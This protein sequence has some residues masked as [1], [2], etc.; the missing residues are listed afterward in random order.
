MKKFLRPSFLVYSLGLGGLFLTDLIVGAVFSP[1]D[2]ADWAKFRSLVGI[3]AVIPLIGLDQVLMRSPASSAQ[4]LRI[5]GV[6][7]PILGV[8][9]GFIL[10][11]F[12]FVSSWVLGAGLAIGS[13]ASLVLFQYFRA[14]R[15]EVLSQFAQQGWKIAALGLIAAMALT[16]WRSDLVVWGIGL[17]LA[18]DIIVALAVLILPPE[19]LHPQSPEP[20]RAHYAIGSRFMVTSLMLALSVYAEQLVVN[21]LGSHME[22]ALYFTSAT[23]FL[24]PLSFLNGYLAFLMGPWVRDKH[25]RFIQL[26][27]TRWWAI[28]LASAGYGVAMGVLGLIL[29]KVVRPSVGEIDAGLV[30]L[31]M[32]TGFIRTLYMLP[33]GYLGVFGM[34]RQHDKLILGQVLSVIP[35]IGLFFLLRAYGVDLVHSVAA[36][37][38]LNWTLRTVLG[39]QM[40]NTVAR[41]RAEKGI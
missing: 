19:R 35:V 29:W 6:Q 2:I 16:G 7:V 20:A 38:A 33:S 14:H 11:W 4:L 34:P 12:G 36:A 18:F 24:F 17:V 3:A 21:R 10:S 22:A 23:Y 15:H 39:F 31:L 5:L 9:I 30:I 8:A 13:A 32:W 1:Q 28:V 40:I 37:S 41:V 27:H 26:L 25:D